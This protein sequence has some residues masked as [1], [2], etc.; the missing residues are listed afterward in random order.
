MHYSDVTWTSWGLKSLTTRWFAQQIV[1]TNKEYITNPLWWESTAVFVIGFHVEA[2]VRSPSQRASNAESVSISWR[3]Y[4]SHFM[5]N[6]VD[7]EYR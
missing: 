5:E 6:T 4:A 1:Q 7:V 2:T 3:H